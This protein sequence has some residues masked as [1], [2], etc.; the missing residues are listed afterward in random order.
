M[1]TITRV[2]LIVLGLLAT[3]TSVSAQTRPSAAIR[4]VDTPEVRTFLKSGG[5]SLHVRYDC[6]PRWDAAYV[7]EVRAII[8]CANNIRTAPQAVLGLTHEVVHAAQHCAHR[9]IPFGT[10][11]EYVSRHNSTLGRALRHEVVSS[12]SPHQISHIRGTYAPS[13]H[14]VEMEA[15]HLQN[16]PDTAF[17]LFYEFCIK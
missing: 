17:K 3:C 15:W 16:S 5:A 14:E 4:A 8:L 12:L 2:A 1:R 7:P 13:H 9:T 10:I 6:P 11:S